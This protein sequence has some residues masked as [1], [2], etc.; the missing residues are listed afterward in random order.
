MWRQSSSAVLVGRRSNMS[1]C[2]LDGR[3]RT[4]ASLAHSSNAAATILASSGADAEPLSLPPMAVDA[5]AALGVPGG[6]CPLALVV[7]PAAVEA[8]PCSSCARRTL[9]G[10]S[11]CKSRIRLANDSLM[12]PGVHSRFCRNSRSKAST[13]SA[14]VRPSPLLCNCLMN[15][16]ASSLRLSLIC[17]GLTAFTQQFSS[18]TP[19]ERTSLSLKSSANCL[20]DIRTNWSSGEPVL[21][22]A[23]GHERCAHATKAASA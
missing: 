16:I 19:S 17:L 11:H 10:S 23:E 6:V 20:S 5:M 21:I 9:S 4:S 22:A 2:H 12:Y 13:I 18:C 15:S 3:P 8:E 1:S 14:S 7:E